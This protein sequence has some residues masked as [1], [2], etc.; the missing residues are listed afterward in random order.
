VSCSFASIAK[1]SLVTVRITG[2]APN[3]GT[4]GASATVDGALPDPNPANDTAS[5][6]VQVR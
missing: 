3:K 6:S 4:V 1:G 2:T 5:A